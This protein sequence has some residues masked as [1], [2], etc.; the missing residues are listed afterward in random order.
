MITPLFE[1]QQDESWIVV[2]LKVP[3]IKVNVLWILL[4]FLQGIWNRFLHSRESVQIFC[5]TLFFEVCQKL[6]VT[7]CLQID[8]FSPSGRRRYGK[9][10]LWLWEWGIN[11]TPS[12][13]SGQKVWVHFHSVQK[14]QFFENLDMLTKLLAKKNP[15]TNPL[16]ETLTLDTEGYLL[17]W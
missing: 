1:V 3:L 13:T 2:I 16:I 12:K 9:S 5:K 17:W 11:N 15:L 10:K 7:N 6:Q 4:I 14:G 8:L